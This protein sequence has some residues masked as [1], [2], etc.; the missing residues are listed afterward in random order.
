MIV[1]AVVIVFI[2]IASVSYCLL[3]WYRR[4][5][6]SPPGPRGIPILGNALFLRKD[7]HVTLR[8]W[9]RK[10]GKVMSVRI[11]RKDWVVINDY[12]SLH[13]AFVKELV[14]F[15]GHPDTPVLKGFSD[16]YHGI[17]FAD[18]GPLWLSQRKFAISTLRRFEVGKRNVETNCLDELSYLTDFIRLQNGQ[19]FDMTDLLHK[20]TANIICHGV[21]GKRFEYEDSTFCK[22]LD[23]L[24]LFVDK[25]ISEW[26][27]AGIL[28]PP[29]RHIPPVSTSCDL[30]LKARQDILDITE[31]IVDDHKNTFKKEVMRD[32]IDCFLKEMKSGKEHFT[33]KQLLHV[34]SD[35]FMAG[36]HTTTNTLRWYL[37]CFLHYPEVQ[38]KLRKEIFAVIGPPSQ[39]NMS[40]LPNM[41]Y[42]NAF[43][44]E[45]NRFYTLLPL[46]FHQTSEDAKLCGFFIPKKT[47]VLANIWSIHNDP[48][49]FEEPH[50]FN[51]ERFIDERGNFVSSKYVIPFNIGGRKC[52]GER[53]AR[54]ELFLF[55]VTI[56]QNFEVLPDPEATALPDT[57]PVFEFPVLAAPSFKIVAQEL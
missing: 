54:M 49:Y 1:E 53:L 17:L 47:G 22:L 21:F 38:N 28:F 36:A 51:P 14:K 35:L 8:D 32:F 33:H 5:S 30:M 6:S 37:H 10:Y 40:H 18:Y 7:P 39:I 31:N 25:D 26:F 27:Q 34:V 44:Q 50:K 3:T 19:A 56:V 2:A 15:A 16:G 57:S 9:G 55:L 29:L 13:Q 52:L 20:A 12:E 11:G 4:P 45:C 41:P 23:L 46:I 42:I 48:N 24:K 43:I